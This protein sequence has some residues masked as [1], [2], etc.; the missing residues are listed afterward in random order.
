MKRW[1]ALGLL[2]NLGVSM[3]LMSWRPLPALGEEQPGE[4]SAHLLIESREAPPLPTASVFEPIIE[5]SN[6]DEKFLSA[7]PDPGPEAETPAVTDEYGPDPAP[8]YEGP[9]YTEPAYT[10]PAALPAAPPPLD[11]RVE[12]SVAPALNLPRGCAAQLDPTATSS[13]C[14]APPAVADLAPASAPSPS[15]SAQEKPPVPVSPARMTTPPA[16][17]L[18]A[19]VAASTPPARQVS[20]APPREVGSVGTSN[21]RYVP[22]PPVL[23]ADRGGNPAGTTVPGT[24]SLPIS[25]PSPGLTS[26]KLQNY[27][28]KPLTGSNPLQWILNGKS[29]LFPLPM[30]V[31]V[32]SAFGW[33]LHPIQQHWHLHSGID[34]AAPQGTPVI[35]AFDGTVAIADYL[36][37][38][39]LS[40]LLDH[41]QGQRQTRY[42]HLSE[43]LV[44]PGQRVK[45][46]DVLGT[47]GS[48]GNS[49]GPHLHFE[50]LQRTADGMQVV[51]PTA[52]L[53]IAL[54]NLI[55]SMQQAAIATLPP[56][57]PVP[58]SASASSAAASSA[59]ASSPG[60]SSQ[61]GRSPS[62]ALPKIPTMTALRPSP[63]EHLDVRMEP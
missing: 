11:S 41:D 16:R 8:V 56:A 15:Q 44:K 36:G 59:A 20:L 46:G 31:V 9:A 4:S 42:A 30:P 62:V 51:D 5:Q 6:W 33:R 37:G 1:V 48:T 26:W 35:A 19:P 58:A 49:T 17:R 23:L 2:T 52:D 25:A 12:P 57:F 28:L 39:G 24:V 32:S 50:L 27:K 18:A 47:V 40:V 63:M 53:Q 54:T 13:V 55:Q 14:A 61:R 21:H 22:S 38:Y 29:M 43:L 45:R 10:E 7:E 60:T 3:G 34:L